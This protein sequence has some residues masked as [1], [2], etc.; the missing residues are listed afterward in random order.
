MLKLSSLTLV[1]FDKERG[2]RRVGVDKELVLCISVL[3]VRFA[4]IVH[5]YC[6]LSAFLRL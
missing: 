5:V 4:A 3:H 6:V 1:I 2:R